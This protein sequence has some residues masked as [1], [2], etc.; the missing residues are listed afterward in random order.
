MRPEPRTG[1]LL[2]SCITALFLFCSN[3]SAIELDCQQCHQKLI[4]GTVVHAAVSM[5]CTTCHTG[6]DAHTV[7]HKKSGTVARGLSAEQPDLCYGCHDKA[8][9]EKTVVHAALGMGCTSCHNPH[10]S[11]TPKLLLSEAPDLCFTCHDKT[12]FSKKTIHAPVAGGMCLTCHVPHSSNEVAL[13]ANKPYDLC[14]TCHSEITEKPH[15]VS[16]FSS[17]GHALGAKKGKKGKAKS[18]LASGSTN[19]L[20][21]PARPG[22]AFYCGSC[23]EPHSTESPRLFR[24]NAKSSISLCSNCHKK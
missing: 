10:S 3:A 14:V 2:F 18:G 20:M 22:R 4:K 15:A 7:P 8:A 23:H 17:A 24:Y 11:N 12:V 6:I 16:G 13:L 1:T 9:F 19:T 5:G 21:D